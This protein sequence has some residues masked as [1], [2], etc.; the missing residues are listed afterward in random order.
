M[1]HGFCP[2]SGDIVFEVPALRFR[3][4]E[5]VVKQTDES[6]YVWPMLLQQGRIVLRVAV[7]LIAA[8]TGYDGYAMLLKLNPLVRLR[9][10]AIVR[11]QTTAKGGLEKRVQPLDVMPITRKLEHEGDATVRSE[12]HVLA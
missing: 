11:Q 2:S 12:H 8:G 10:V 6:L 4:V 9:P 7:L 5:L 3:R 1:G